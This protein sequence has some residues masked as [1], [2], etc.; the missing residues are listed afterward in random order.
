M[1]LWTLGCM[2]L[3][4]LVFLFSLDLY[5]GVELLDHKVVPLWVFWETSI[6]FPIVVTPIYIPTNS[7]PELP[8]LHILASI[9]ICGLF[10]DSHSYR[11]EIVSHCGFLFA[12]DDSRCWTSF[13]SLHKPKATSWILNL[14]FA[15]NKKGK[16]VSYWVYIYF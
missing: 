2:Y 9:F 8:F 14:P 1:L 12:F 5:P 4:K 3:F 6:L 11:C 10:D 13:I 16:L 15:F 7:V